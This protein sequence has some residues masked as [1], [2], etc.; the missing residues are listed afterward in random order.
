MA[1]QVSCGYGFTA[2]LSESG[3]LMLFG[4]NSKGQCDKKNIRREKIRQ[5]IC[6]GNHVAIL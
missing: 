4:S 6:G 2:I 3:D 5:V 1:Q